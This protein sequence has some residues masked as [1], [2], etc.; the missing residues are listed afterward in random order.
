MESCLASLVNIGSNHLIDPPDP[1]TKDRR[2]GTA[3]ESIVPYQAFHC[4]DG[5]IVLAATNNKQYR[6]LC[7]DVL[8]EPALVDDARFSE[9]PQRVVHRET[10]IPLLQGRFKVESMGHWLGKLHSAGIPAGP[11]NSIGEAFGEVQATHRKMVETIQ[12][13]TAGE[14][15]LTGVPVKFGETPESIRL[16]PPLLGEHTDEVLRKLLDYG[17]GQIQLLRENGVI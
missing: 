13:P 2:W 5:E 14:I 17:D 15:Q 1:S 12:H 10:L 3:H 11:I 16:P 6:A 8:G 9:N 4:S 7:E